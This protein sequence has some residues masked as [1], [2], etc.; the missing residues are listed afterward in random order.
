[1]LFVSV[2][3]VLMGSAKPESGR[4]RAQKIIFFHL[5]SPSEIGSFLTGPDWLADICAGKV[6]SISIS[7]VAAETLP[8]YFFKIPKQFPM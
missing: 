5:F 1:M 8:T 4:N 3:G 6:P 7:A 2:F